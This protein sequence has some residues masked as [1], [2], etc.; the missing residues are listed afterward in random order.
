MVHPRVVM[1][2]CALQKKSGRYLLH[3]HFATATP[4][5]EARVNNPVSE[6][7][8]HT[9]VCDQCQ[10]GRKSQSGPPIKKLTKPMA[11]SKLLTGEF[12]KRCS[13]VQGRCVDGS[14]HQQCTGKRAGGAAIYPEDLYLAI[15][16]GIVEQLAADGMVSASAHG[17]LPPDAQGRNSCRNKGAYGHCTR[18]L[19][20]WHR[21]SDSGRP[22]D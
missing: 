9:S 8:V 7:A 20:G 3:E 21:W 19:H 17:T 22:I 6:H 12:V 4:W 14:E 11:N 16:N 5:Q 10:Y 15:L 2:L 1:E 13:G 18:P